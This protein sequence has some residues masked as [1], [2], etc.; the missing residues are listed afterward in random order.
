MLGK[1]ARENLVS[2]LLEQVRPGGILSLQYTD[3]TLLFSSGNLKA[4]RK[5]K[6]VL[7]LFENVSG[8]K[9]N[10]HKSKFVPMNLDDSHIHE[11]AHILNCPVGNL[12][13]QYLGIPLHFE[14]LKIEDLQSVVNKML[15]KVVGWRGKLLDYSSRVVLIKSC[16][17]SIAIY[18]LSFIKFSKW[19][20]KL[21]E[22]QMS[23]CLWNN[24]ED[25]HKY[26]LAGWKH[27]AM[28]KEYGG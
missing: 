2:R 5:L 8:M 9:I 26:H 16:M 27:V 24:T 19:A 25:A 4:I 28:K 1:A 12:P 21:I 17:A 10:F 23:H 11:I 3:D 20:F 22:S 15:K 18:L 13:M 6:C 14:K 7:M